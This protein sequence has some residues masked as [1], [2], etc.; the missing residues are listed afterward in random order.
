MKQNENTKYKMSTCCNI[1]TCN[2]LDHQELLTIVTKEGIS[3]VCNKKS[4]MQCTLIYDICCDDDDGSNLMHTIPLK[5]IDHHI[6]QQ[7]IRFCDHHHYNKT[8]KE[9]FETHVPKC[10]S[11]KNLFVE[12]ITRFDCSFFIEMCEMNLHVQVMTA[13]DFIGL[14]HL[15]NVMAFGI[16]NAMK[17][18]RF[19]SKRKIF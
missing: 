17:R 5:N 3:L 15:T 7:I 6:M 9:S 14:S 10:S 16:S 18:K 19:E 1:N 8:K 4:L 11:L 2:D 13:S 12:K